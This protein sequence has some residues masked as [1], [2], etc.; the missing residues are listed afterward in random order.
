MSD[1][2]N[3]VDT[4]AENTDVNIDDNIKKTSIINTEYFETLNVLQQ[5]SFAF[6]ML[7]TVTPTDSCLINII[8]IFKFSPAEWAGL[9]GWLAGRLFN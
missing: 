8:F 6:L 4:N 3:N 1:T 7:Q 2:N 9:A 5:V